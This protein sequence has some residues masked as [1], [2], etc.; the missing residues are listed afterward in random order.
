[1]I[2]HAQP[3]G[4]V[5]TVLDPTT[6]RKRLRREMKLISQFVELLSGMEEAERFAWITWLAD[7]FL[8]ARV[9]EQMRRFRF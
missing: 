3:T 4:E 7:R 1:M 9:A 6:S 8:G 5:G 2:E